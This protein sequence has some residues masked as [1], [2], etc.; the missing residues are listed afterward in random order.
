MESSAEEFS[1]QSTEWNETQ[2]EWDCFSE[3]TEDGRAVESPFV[4]TSLRVF[5]PPP[6]FFFTQQL[7]NQFADFKWMYFEHPDAGEK[8]TGHGLFIKSR[9]SSAVSAQ[10]GLWW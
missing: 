10:R 8:H 4:L 2:R 7:R 1:Q 6:P 5:I 3:D 9:R